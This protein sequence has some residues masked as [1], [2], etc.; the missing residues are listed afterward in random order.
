[1]FNVKGEILWTETADHDRAGKYS[2]EV[3][4]RNWA[5]GVY[6]Y[7]IIWQGPEGVKISKARKMIY[8]P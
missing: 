5:R 7:K 2:F 4:P 3:N 8:I 6:F 1:V